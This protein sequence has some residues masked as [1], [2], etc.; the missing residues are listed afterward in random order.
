MARD[1]IEHFKIQLRVYAEADEADREVASAVDAERGV[2]AGGGYGDASSRSAT[3]PGYD[4]M[5]DFLSDGPRFA[6]FSRCSRSAPTDWRLSAARRTAR[7]SSRPCWPR[8]SV[9]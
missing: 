6:V 9:W 3:P 4:L 7:R 1:A 2:G 5:I 8:W